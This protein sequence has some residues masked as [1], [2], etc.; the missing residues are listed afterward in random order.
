[1]TIEAIKT[2]IEPQIT[3]LIENIVKAQQSEGKQ[4]NLLPTELQ[5]DYGANEKF[6]DMKKLQV[7]NRIQSV[8][9]I[10]YSMKAK[11]IMPILNKLIDEGID[12]KSIDE[13]IKAHNEEEKA[14]QIEF[15][16]I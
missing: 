8:G 12:E 13:L 14:M 6:D 3:H 15:G 16:E 1:M 5:W 11:I 4:E 10:P 7:L 9:A 2:Q